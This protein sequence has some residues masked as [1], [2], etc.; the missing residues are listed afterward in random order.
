MKAVA[1]NLKR[2]LLIGQD[3]DRNLNTSSSPKMPYAGKARRRRANFHF[4]THFVGSADPTRETQAR[5]SP[6]MWIVKRNWEIPA[7]EDKELAGR[8]AIVR[9]TSVAAALSALS[10]LCSREFSLLPRRRCS[11]RCSISSHGFSISESEREKWGSTTE[12]PRQLRISAKSAASAAEELSAH[13]ARTSFSP[14][15][16]KHDERVLVS[17]ELALEGAVGELEDVLLLGEH[18]QQ[19]QRQN[20]QALSQHLHGGS[21]SFAG[22]KLL[23]SLVSGCPSRTC[24]SA[25]RQ[26]R[27]AVAR[28][29]AGRRHARACAYTGCLG[30]LAPVNLTVS[31]AGFSMR[32]LLYLI[33]AAVCL[34]TDFGWLSR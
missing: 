23:C 13:K 5:A 27:S 24:G 28:R 25:I 21:G 22:R 9:E 12:L 3:S 16:I 15:C 33:V 34:I 6:T 19:Q 8:F 32:I 26:A 2:V 29:L 17:V 10:A 1:R 30:K 18:A 20:R 4:E 14:W 31:A 11:V 7:R